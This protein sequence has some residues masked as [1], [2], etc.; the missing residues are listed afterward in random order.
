MAFDYKKKIR[1]IVKLTIFALV[2]A[3]AGPFFLKDKN[4]KPFLSV[5]KIKVAAYLKYIELKHLLKLDTV[6][7][8]ETETITGGHTPPDDREYTE[9]YK[10]YDEKGVPHFTNIKPVNVKY[11]VM[12][13]PV[14]KDKKTVGKKLDGF[15]DTVFDKKNKKKKTEEKNKPDSA[16]NKSYGSGDMLS[17][18]KELLKNAA[19]QYK[20]AP[21]A[22]D[23]A[24]DL[25]KQVEKVYQER[26]KAMKGSAEN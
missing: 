20:D 15:I 7:K 12:Y 23:E 6:P 16:K 5:E 17:Q 1:T 14:S 10:F 22:L 18:A 13:M 19:D 25:K 26:E 9:M 21:K 24:K 4:G 8:P 11:E 2:L 3:C